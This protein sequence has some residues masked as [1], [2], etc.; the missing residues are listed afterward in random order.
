M[1]V[2]IIQVLSSMAAQSCTM[3]I[4][5]LKHTNSGFRCIIASGRNIHTMQLWGYNS[6][7]HS[8]I[9]LALSTMYCS[10]SRYNAIVLNL[11]PRRTVWYTDDI[12]CPKLVT[13]VPDPVG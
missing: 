3:L 9:Y 13:I 7:L 1:F 2:Y 11:C 4:Q 10:A 12:H 8:F 5:L 6:C